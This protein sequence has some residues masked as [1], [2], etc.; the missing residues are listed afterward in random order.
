MQHASQCNKRIKSGLTGIQT[1]HPGSRTTKCQ[2]NPRKPGGT[3][4][5]VKTPNF[6]KIPKLKPIW[7]LGS[8]TPKI[9]K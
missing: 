9:Q 3:Q 2:E 7:P 4:N 8:K 1:D 5:E 6:E